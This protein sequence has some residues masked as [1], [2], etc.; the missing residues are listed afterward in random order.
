MQLPARAD[1]LLC[2]ALNRRERGA[3]IGEMN[4]KENFFLLPFFPL[5]SSSSTLRGMG[6]LDNIGEG[7]RAQSTHLVYRLWTTFK[8]KPQ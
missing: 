3:Q 5:S 8:K 6:C 2:A 1:S 7:N 4:S